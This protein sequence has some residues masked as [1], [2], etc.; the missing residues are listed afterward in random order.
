MLKNNFPVYFLLFFSFLVFLDNVNAQQ[1][2]NHLFKPV[3]SFVNES[4]KPL[5]NL[6]NDHS[7]V[8]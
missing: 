7:I 8:S 2:Y 3:T 5:R 6:Q 4:E 1:A